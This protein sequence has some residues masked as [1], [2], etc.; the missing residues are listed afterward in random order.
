MTVDPFAP[1]GGDANA[2]LAKQKAWTII[3]PVPPEAPKPLVEHFKLGKPT[4]RW[5]YTDAAGD[6]LFYAVRFDTGNGEKQFRP[7]TLWKPASGGALQWRWESWPQ[8]RPLYGLQGLAE[9]PSASVVVC[10]GEKAADAATRLL[11][12]FVAVTSPNGSKSAAKADWS[13]LRGRDVVIWPDADAAGLEYGRQVAKLAAAAGALSV[14]IVS[15]PE[16]ARVD[17]DAA[18][19]LAESWDTARTA[20]LLAAARPIAGDA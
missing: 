5:T 11:P 9:R 16:G 2:R 15:P 1:I 18:D 12:G 17:W 14:A 8:K 7:L 10:E 3:V 4:A 19:A 13:P 20:E 6:V